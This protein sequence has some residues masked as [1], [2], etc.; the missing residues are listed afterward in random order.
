VSE[1]TG[2]L[3]VT[4]AQVAVVGGGPAGL[5]VAIEAALRGLSVVVL[6][7]RTYPVDK[8]CGEGLMPS[9]LVAL[10]RLGALEYLDLTQTAP[11]EAIRYV[12]EDG[13][14]VDGMLPAPGGLGVRRLALSAA[15]AARARALGVVLK[16]GA[17]VRAHSLRADGVTLNTDADT[18]EAEVLVAAD[19]LNSPLR[20]ALGL[21][22]E[23]RGPRRFGLRRHLQLA[24]WGPRVEVH[25]AD[26]VEAYVTPVGAGRV[27]VAFLWSE[28]LLKTPT[29]FDALLA[30]FPGLQARVGGAGFDSQVRGAGPLRQAVRRRAVDRA[31]L[32]GDA[33]GYVDAI[34][35]E[36]LSLAF[37]GA[38]ALGAC[39]PEVLAHGGAVA[40]FRPYEVAATRAFAR[41]ARLAGALVWVASR[42]RLR[43]QVVSQLVAHPALFGWALRAGLEH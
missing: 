25:F 24:P 13:E 15:L 32:L 14:Y 5:A 22:L 10:R 27:G 17:G 7:R 26:G 20:H 8:A 21:Q 1:S 16:Q 34:T 29:D 37:E 30:R 40:A 3:P 11:F 2:S 19:G 4:R 42:P 35:G 38:H 36:G 39:L 12:Q 18:V 33:A 43:R 41:Y 23:A 6:E 9:G 31:V 28:G